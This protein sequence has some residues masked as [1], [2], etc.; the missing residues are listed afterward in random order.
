MAAKIRLKRVGKKNQPGYRIV[1]LDGRKDNQ[2]DYLEYLG[3]YNNRMKPKILEINEER[4]KYWLK[5][6][7]QPSDTVKSLFKQKGI[8]K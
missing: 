2:G 1:V 3:H 5:V 7:A 4:A 6:G 8:L